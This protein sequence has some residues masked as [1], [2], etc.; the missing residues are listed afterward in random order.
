MTTADEAA[1]IVG[2]M[3][4]GHVLEVSALPILSSRSGP[5]HP[6][7]QEIAPR[8]EESAP[9]LA[10]MLVPV[11]IVSRRVMVVTQTCDLQARK[12]S[13]GRVLAHVA[14]LVTLA[15]KDWDDAFRDTRPSLVRVPW[16]GDDQFADLDQMAAVDRGLLARAAVGPGPSE[17]E[18]RPLAYRLGRYFGRAALPDEVIKAL[19][20]LQRTAD[21]KHQALRK[22]LDAVQQIR[23]WSDPPY[24]F[25][26]PYSLSV[27]IVVDSDWY[28]DAPPARFRD[29]GKELHSTASAMVEAYDSADDT[30]AGVLV[31][32]W[33]RFVAQLSARL[34]N[35]LAGRSGG[36]V[37]AIS[38]AI[39]TTLTPRE[40]DESD[41]LDFGHLSLTTDE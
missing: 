17:D 28:P 34:D 9:G 14:P 20:P 19:Q 12:T 38:L 7:A 33:Q 40:F 3:R 22:V 31:V 29:T 13:A 8:G 23:V 37:Q 10:P 21:P 5:L 36:V 41:A 30:L 39:A 25:E 32:L 6:A 15:G 16:A 27:I 1:Q 24:D 2:G 35:D 26:G 11:A 4:Q 18:R